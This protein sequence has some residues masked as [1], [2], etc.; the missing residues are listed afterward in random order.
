MPDS[1]T[2]RFDIEVDAIHIN[3]DVE[4]NTDGKM[5]FN[6]KQWN[7]PMSSEDLTMLKTIL[8]YCHEVTENFGEIKL[9]RIKKKVVGE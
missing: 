9:I 1:Y 4:F 5:T 8:D 2:H 7:N 6:V 3:G